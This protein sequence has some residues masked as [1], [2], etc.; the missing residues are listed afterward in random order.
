MI[1]DATITAVNRKT[2]NRKSDNKTITLYEIQDSTGAKTSTSRR[3]LANEA[4]RLLQQ[5]AEL[6][7]RVEQNG[8]Y[9]NR[10]L[11]DIRASTGAVQRQ[12]QQPFPEVP[13][14]TPQ[15]APQEP[16][17]VADGEGTAKDWTVWRQTAT[18]VA[19]QLAT[20]PQEFW[21]NVGQLITF[22]ATGLQPELTPPPRQQQQEPV[23]SYAPAQAAQQAAERFIPENVPQTDDHYT[24]T[25]DDIPF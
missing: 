12:T 15:Q 11:D 1:Y 21:D 7:V 2:I 8:S 23:T 6:S 14:S 18:K 13:Q 16:R 9:E 19:A 24:H 20:T 3:D 10:Y 5:T 22:Y 25:D 17:I 4:H